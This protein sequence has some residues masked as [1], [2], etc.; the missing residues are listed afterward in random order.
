MG[1]VRHLSEALC[2]NRTLQELILSHNVIDN[3]GV[4]HLAKALVGNWSLRRLCLD[5]NKSIAESIGD[6]SA[7]YLADA[8]MK[9]RSLEELDLSMNRVGEEGLQKLT[10]ALQVNSFL[11]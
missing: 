4:K 5:S 7:E 2:E 3:T 11:H 8:L 10:M 9:N 1:G 6:N